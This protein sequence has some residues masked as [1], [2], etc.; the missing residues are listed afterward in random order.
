[1]AGRSLSLRSLARHRLAGGP[2]IALS[3]REI[4][5]RPSGAVRLGVRNAQISVLTHNMALLV[6]PAPYLGTD[7][8]GVVS[9]ICARIRVL[10]PD[11]VGLCEVFS[12]GER[13]EIYAALQDLYPFFREGPD[14]D[15]VE[16]DGGLLLLSRFPLLA[17]NDFIFR[18]CDGWDCWANKGIL[19]IRVRGPGWP[20]ALDIFYSHMQDIS[21]SDGQSALYAQLASMR[22]FVELHADIDL[23]AIILGD[24]NIPAGNSAHYTELLRTLR[25]FRDTWTLVGNTV[26]SGATHVV[27][28][29]FYEDTDDRPGQDKRLDYILLRAGRRACAITADVEVMRFTHNGRFI[30]DH[31]GVWAVFDPFAAVGS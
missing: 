5:G 31:F 14:E 15:D 21:T 30:S 11:I 2:G 1:M 23:P 27:N 3:V 8:E 29:D 26:D 7:R 17:V 9:E 25:G 6:F 24:L 28:N 13:A 22:E 10:S 4:L 16:S 12:D 19:H 18:D 20:S